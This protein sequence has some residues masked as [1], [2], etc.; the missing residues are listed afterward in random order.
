LVTGRVLGAPIRS[1]KNKLT[2]EFEKL[3]ERKASREEFEIFGLGALRRAVI[4]GDV[5][6]GSVMAGQIAGLICDIK[7]CS[8]IIEDIMRE[9][10]ENL[11]KL[12]G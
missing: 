2:R 9:Y 1:L 6:N 5:K 7:P 8:E 4:E 11:S 10:E 12:R 3:E